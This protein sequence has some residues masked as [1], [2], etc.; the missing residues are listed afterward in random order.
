M[1]TC[2]RGPRG[3]RLQ[4][5]GAGG[6]VWGAEGQRGAFPSL[7]LACFSGEVHVPQPGL[8]PA[9]AGVPCTDQRQLPG[10]F[11]RC[12]AIP[13]EQTAALRGARGTL[14]TPLGPPP[15]IPV[16]LRPQ[17]LPPD[18]SSHGRGGE[19]GVGRLHRPSPGR[20][21]FSVSRVATCH[22]AGG[23]QRPWATS[24]PASSPWGREGKVFPHLLARRGVSWG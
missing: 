3:A 7:L 2:K 23:H 14:P 10:P 15:P 17:S 12:A 16:E 4:D 24:D 6:C 20:I 18:S 19:G 11:L 5:C 13:D 22:V 9:G 1:Q 21:L 8:A